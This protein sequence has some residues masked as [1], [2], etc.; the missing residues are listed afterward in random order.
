LSVEGLF[1]DC[2]PSS[3]CSYIY[4]CIY[5]IVLL[6][7]CGLFLSISSFSFFCCCRRI[8]LIL[9]SSLPQAQRTRCPETNGRQPMGKVSK[10]CHTMAAGNAHQYSCEGHFQHSFIIANSNGAEMKVRSIL[11]TWHHNAPL[12]QNTHTTIYIY[13]EGFT[14]PQLC[15]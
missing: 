6:C 2:V 13:G 3:R 15:S 12:A 14:Y 1:C 7:L 8:Q 5:I 4:I 11:T 9:I 10:I